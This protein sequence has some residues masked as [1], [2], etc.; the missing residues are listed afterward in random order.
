MFILDWI[1]CNVLLKQ[2]DDR[3]VI[4]ATLPGQACPKLMNTQD[5]S[6]GPVTVEV[7]D[8]CVRVCVLLQRTATL[9]L[10]LHFTSLRFEYRFLFPLKR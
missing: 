4:F 9:G 6:D 1:S 2:G 7:K 3:Q 10:P 5:G 8:V